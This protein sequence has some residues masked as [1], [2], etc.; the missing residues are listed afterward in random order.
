VTNEPRRKGT[1]AETAV[2]QWF[3]DIGEPQVERHA[4]HGNKDLGD[5]TGVPGC[6][7]SIKFVGKGKPMDLSGW[8]RELA[9]MQDNVEK[10]TR[11]MSGGLSSEELPVGLLV[12]RRAGYR[13]PADWYAIQPLGEWWE[14]FKEL[15][16]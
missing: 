13:S 9:V 10:R 8:L 16:T 1:A 12:V 4:L 5:L 6:V 15:L 14:T 2:V 11:A 7:V 3:H